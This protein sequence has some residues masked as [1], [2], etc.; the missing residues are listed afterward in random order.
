[1]SDELQPI[2]VLHIKHPVM[3]SEHNDPRSGRW[4]EVPMLSDA[5]LER[6]IAVMRRGFD[7][8][9]ADRTWPLDT[10]IVRLSRSLP[11]RPEQ[12][13]IER[14]DTTNGRTVQA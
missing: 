12:F 13:Y 10:Q 5:D 11:D 9:V 1:M 2:A 7:L 14:L 3:P 8:F 6:S 4:Y